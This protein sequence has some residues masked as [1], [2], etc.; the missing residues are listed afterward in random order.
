MKESSEPPAWRTEKRPEGEGMA[1]S[2]G[3][4]EWNP[5]QSSWQLDREE[6]CQRAPVLE[7]DGLPS[8]VTQA[9]GP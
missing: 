2:M 3:E 5:T 8:L 7:G 6:R 9:A 4:A 1:G